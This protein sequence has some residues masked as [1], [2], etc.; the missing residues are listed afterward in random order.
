MFCYNPTNFA[1]IGPELDTDD[2]LRVLREA[3]ALGAVQ[4]GLSGGE[5]LLRD[6]LEVIVAE[7]HALGFYTNLDHLRRRPQ[8]DA[9]RRTEEPRASITSSCR[10]R[11]ARGR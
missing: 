10:S 3:R 11:T 1:T 8:R 4:L 2:W 6:D 5:P 9:H 7:A